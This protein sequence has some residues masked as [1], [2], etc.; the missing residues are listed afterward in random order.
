MILCMRQN[1]SSIFFATFP[2]TRE[3][4]NMGPTSSSFV[5]HGTFSR[6]EG[7]CS[8]IK[9][10]EHFWIQVLSMNLKSWELLIH[11]ELIKNIGT[12]LGIRQKRPHI[13]RWIV[14]RWSWDSKTK[15]ASIKVFPP[16]CPG[17]PTGRGCAFVPFGSDFLEVR[18]GTLLYLCCTPNFTDLALK[19]LFPSQRS[20]FWVEMGS[21]SGTA[22]NASKKC[23]CNAMPFYGKSWWMLRH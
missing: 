17:D 7:Q 21:W 12:S 8:S 6:S 1:G 4:K 19:R 13:F 20:K 22:E 15:V 9:G 2:Q 23:W 3:K 5:E 11:S 16:R 18:N 14:G 10:G